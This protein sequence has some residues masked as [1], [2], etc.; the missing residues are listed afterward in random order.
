MI[1]ISR[2][3][4]ITVFFT[5]MFVAIA[6]ARKELMEHAAIAY[7]SWVAMSLLLKEYHHKD[8]K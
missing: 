4:L 5:G 1:Q 7:L 6:F 2:L 3:T 8:V